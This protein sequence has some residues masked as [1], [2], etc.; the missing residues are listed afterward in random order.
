MVLMQHR[1][2]PRWLLF[3]TLLSLLPVPSLA[4]QES[5]KWLAQ[6]GERGLRPERQTIGLFRFV[7][8]DEDVE[9]IHSLWRLPRD[10]RTSIRLAHARHE[11][12]GDFVLLRR[13]PSS[14]LGVDPLADVQE[15]HEAYLVLERD[16]SAIAL[17]SLEKATFCRLVFDESFH[18]RAELARGLDL[19]LREIEG[20]QALMLASGRGAAAMADTVAA[21]QAA[22]SRGDLAASRLRQID[23]DLKL[24]TQS[25][26]QPEQPV[27][28]PNHQRLWDLISLG[29]PTLISLEYS[30]LLESSRKARD[31]MRASLKTPGFDERAKAELRSRSTSIQRGRELLE[32]LSLMIPTTAEGYSPPGDIGALSD[33]QRYERAGQLGM[34]A[35][36]VDPLNPRTAYLCA[37]AIDFKLGRRTAAPFYDRFLALSGIRYYDSSTLSGRVLTPEETQALIAVRDQG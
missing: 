22:L 31:L 5:G 25:I 20:V 11:R 27:L 7:R 4:L 26:L 28:H 2:N 35:V 16:P 15:L 3:L 6:D 9:F 24:L 33:S 29:D 14:S 17:S 32:E 1:L 36:G 8:D 23:R 13:S 30:K 10:V 37:I 19:E 21:F 34:A 12:R 18:L